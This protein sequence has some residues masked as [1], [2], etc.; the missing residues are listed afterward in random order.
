[1]TFRFGLPAGRPEFS[2][3]V[4]A[5]LWITL[6]GVLFTVTITS[7]RKVTPDL[8]VFEAVMF[9]SLFGI[10]F[11]VPWL[12]RRGISQMRTHRIGLF[13]IRGSLAFFVTTLYFWAA[14]MMPLADLVS[15]TFTRPIFGTIAAIIF[16][17]EVARARRWSAIAA[18]FIGM[19]IIIRPGFATL[20][21]GM[22][23]V[24]GGVCFQT[25]NTIIVKTL[26]RTEQS[27]TIALYHTL[28]ILPLSIVPAIIFWKTLT[29]V[30]L[31]WLMAVGGCGMMSQRAMT[32]ALAA[33]DASFV[34]ALSY[35]RLPIAALIG[36]LVFGEVPVIWVW[37]GGT[38]IAASSAYIARREAVIARAEKKGGGDG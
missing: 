36:F 2:A 30:Q 27:D 24:L 11:M 32:R 22:L 7:V 31:G 26:T 21:V 20:N 28:F 1:M 35:L 25:C 8:H 15:I 13:A 38:V 4:R 12:I 37:I 18:G 6:A 33:A 9:R 5:A 29:L 17:H 10:V 14:T 19:L 3:P 23:L 16:L 34:L